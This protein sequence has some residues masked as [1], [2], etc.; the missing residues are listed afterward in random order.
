MVV[1][2]MSLEASAITGSST[3]LVVEE[4]W[5]GVL[6]VEESPEGKFPHIEWIFWSGF[7]EVPWGWVGGAD[8]G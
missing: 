6:F 7:R 8:P 2:G 5:E 1:E 3:F 4:L